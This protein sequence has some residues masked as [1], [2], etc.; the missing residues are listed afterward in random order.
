MERKVVI[1]FKKH[2]LMVYW[3]GGVQKLMTEEK[4]TCIKLQI[5]VLDLSAYCNIVNTPIMKLVLHVKKLYEYFED[6][7]QKCH[8]TCMTF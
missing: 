5:E 8:D 3:G 2:V 4:K 7:L 1:K 6:I